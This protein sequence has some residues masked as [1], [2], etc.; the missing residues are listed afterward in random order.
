[1]FVRPEE[2]H[3][4]A[5]V[6]KVLSLTASRGECIERLRGIKQL[7]FDKVSESRFRP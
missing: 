3:I 2:T 6:I 5:D 1:M 4:T 7:G